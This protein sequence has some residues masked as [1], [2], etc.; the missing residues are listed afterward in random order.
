M[1]VEA[2]ENNAVCQIMGARNPGRPDIVIR[3]NKSCVYRV[4]T[5]ARSPYR[6]NRR[7]RRCELGLGV[8]DPARCGCAIRNSVVCTQIDAAPGHERGTSRGTRGWIR[9]PVAVMAGQAELLRQDVI[10]IIGRVAG[11]GS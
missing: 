8:N 9:G 11:R 7:I 10:N 5:V 4:V 2:V 3:G 1:A 6:M